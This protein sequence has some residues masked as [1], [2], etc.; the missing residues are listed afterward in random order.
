MHKKIT[1]NSVTLAKKTKAVILVIGLV[2][3]EFLC[4]SVEFFNLNHIK[5]GERIS[6]L[7]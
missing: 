5:N 2:V 6:A 3:F 4:Q 7:G 1:F